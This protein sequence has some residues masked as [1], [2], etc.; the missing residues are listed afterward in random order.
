MDD[1][2]KAEKFKKASSKENKLIFLNQAH[3]ILIAQV[4]MFLMAIDLGL[5][6]SCHFPPS[7]PSSLPSSLFSSLS[8]LTTV[9]LPQMLTFGET[10]EFPLSDS[11]Y[12][13]PLQPLKNIYLP[14]V[15][16]L[17]KVKL[18]IGKNIETSTFPE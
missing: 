14:H 4:G 8:L 2:T 6:L 12:A 18:R 9:F 7:P 15:M 11:D 13:S 16:L 17:A 10:I 1:L 3:R 5:V